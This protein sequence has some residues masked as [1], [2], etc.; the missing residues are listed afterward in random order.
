MSSS[1]TSRRFKVDAKSLP[2]LP[3]MMLVT[4]EALRELGGSASVQETR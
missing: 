2:Y 4:V 1:A 3:G